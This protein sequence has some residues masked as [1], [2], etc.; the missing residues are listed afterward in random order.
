MGLY[1]NDKVKNMPVKLG[2]KFSFKLIS[3]LE[4]QKTKRKQKKLEKTI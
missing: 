4:D 3:I 1:G 2:G